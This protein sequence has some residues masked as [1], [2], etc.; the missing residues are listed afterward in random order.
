MARIFAPPHSP[1]TAPA[2]NVNPDAD[3]IRTLLIKAVHPLV[4][5]ARA[6][7]WQCGRCAASGLFARL[8]ARSGPAARQRKGI[9]FGG[10]EPMLC[11]FARQGQ[12]G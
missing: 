2:S 1:P 9:G 6:F 10:G 4:R 7:A 3:S 8:D 5:K 11:S 12:S